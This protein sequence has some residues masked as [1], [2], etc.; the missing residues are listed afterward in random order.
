[1]KQLV[2]EGPVK[3]FLLKLPGGPGGDREL[4]H[5]DVRQRHEP[6]LTSDRSC[7]ERGAALHIYDIGHTRAPTSRHYPGPA[8]SKS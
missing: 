1:M 7:C 2:R 4:A 5:P 8:I 3:T 6:P